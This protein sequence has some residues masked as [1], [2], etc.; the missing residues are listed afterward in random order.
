MPEDP[1]R[2]RFPMNVTPQ[3]ALRQ[4]GTIAAGYHE[5]VERKL[6]KFI[7]E[8]DE[9]KGA[10]VA[11][12]GM[13]QQARD[14]AKASRAE[15]RALRDDVN[16]L[17]RAVQPGGLQLAPPPR[18]PSAHEIAEELQDLIEEHTNPGVEKKSDSERARE[19]VSRIETSQKAKKWDEQQKFKRD[20]YIAAAGLVLGTI[21]LAVLA[22]FWQVAKAH[23]AG[24]SEER[25]RSAV[26]MPVPMPSPPPTAPPAPPPP[27]P[28]PPASAT[29]RHRP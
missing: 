15:V 22:V 11:A 2:P 7:E 10:A 12:C 17:L 23:D 5:F 14:D 6:P 25:Q 9:M 19:M 28:P 21:A 20:V 29:V 3:E 13:A 8:I 27:E 4:Y 18:I 16:A 24:V 1:P 26:V